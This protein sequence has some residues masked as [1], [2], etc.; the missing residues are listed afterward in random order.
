MNGFAPPHKYLNCKDD[1]QRSSKAKSESQGRPRRQS[2]RWPIFL[3]VTSQDN[4]SQGH[5]T[6]LL[7]KNPNDN[8]FQT[9]YRLNCEWKNYSRN[10]R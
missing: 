7:Q 10:T 2:A 5:R 3:Y 1:N 9:N 8:S 4:V 6:K